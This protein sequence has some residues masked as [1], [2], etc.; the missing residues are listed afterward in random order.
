MSKSTILA[1]SQLSP[2]PH[3]TVTIELIE[4]DNMPAVVIVSWPPKPTVLHPQRFPDI[5]AM[6]A[7]L[8]L[9]QPPN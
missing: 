9:R 8:S 1:E 4:A 5:A 3:N 7:G 6:V 2:S